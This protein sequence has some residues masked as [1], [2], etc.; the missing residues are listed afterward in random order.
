MR[1]LMIVDEQDSSVAVWQAIPNGHHHKR[2]ANAAR[3]MR[4]TSSSSAAT[5]GLDDVT[6]EQSRFPIHSKDPR[7]GRC[8][9]SL[10]CGQDSWTLRLLPAG[11]SERQTGLFCTAFTFGELTRR[12]LYLPVL[13]RR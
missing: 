12:C 9:L 1:V 2:N 8:L 7:P 6:Q 10:R 11:G 3:I 13:R 4:V 5:I